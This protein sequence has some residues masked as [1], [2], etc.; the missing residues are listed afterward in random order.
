MSSLPD[1]IAAFRQSVAQYPHE[2]PKQYERARFMRDRNRALPRLNC[3]S[4]SVD[5]DGR[6][7]VYPKEAQTVSIPTDVLEVFGEDIIICPDRR[8]VH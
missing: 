2:F 3:H 6:L 4:F 5:D 8:H 7:L 1:R